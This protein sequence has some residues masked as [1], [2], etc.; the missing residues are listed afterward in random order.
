MEGLQ[1]RQLCLLWTERLCT[2]SGCEFQLVTSNTPPNTLRSRKQ[3]STSSE[4]RRRKAPNLHALM[5][6]M[7]LMILAKLLLVRPENPQKDVTVSVRH[8]LVMIRIGECSYPATIECVHQHRIVLDN[9][10]CVSGVNI[11]DEP[12]SAAMHAH[13]RRNAPA[14]VSSQRGTSDTWLRRLSSGGSTEYRDQSDRPAPSV[15]TTETKTGLGR[16]RPVVVRQNAKEEQWVI[17]YRDFPL[18]D[19]RTTWQL[20]S[21]PN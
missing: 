17:S 19:L 4:P 11:C 6:R 2:V 20:S 1:Q 10:L 18:C 15:T 21:A 14:T 7:I 9:L 8:R 3:S 16:L 13:T 12:K 5:F